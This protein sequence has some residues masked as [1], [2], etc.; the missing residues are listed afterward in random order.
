[1]SSENVGLHGDVWNRCGVRYE[2][3]VFRYLQCSKEG[4]VLELINNSNR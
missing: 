2:D 3:L 1:M 4:R